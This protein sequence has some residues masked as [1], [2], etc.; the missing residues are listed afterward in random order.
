MIGKP[1]TNLQY[2]YTGRNND[3][4]KV[5]MKENVIPLAIPI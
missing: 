1:K 2:T 4:K 5:K 3:S